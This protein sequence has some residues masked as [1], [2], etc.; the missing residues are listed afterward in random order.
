LHH[1]ASDT[2]AVSYNFQGLDRAPQGPLH[3]HFC[4][5]IR[6]THTTAPRHSSITHLSTVQ[7]MTPRWTHL[8]PALLHASMLLQYSHAPCIAHPYLAIRLCRT[9][10]S[11][12]HQA[13][14]HMAPELIAG[15]VLEWAPTTLDVGPLWAS[16]PHVITFTA[17]LDMAYLHTYPLWAAFAAKNAPMNRT[18]LPHHG[19]NTS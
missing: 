13:S 19:P 14:S 2:C 7:S 3:L 4:T 1:S 10:K 5:A 8:A 15:S 11:T 6:D 12:P 9:C 17:Y 16:T 18:G